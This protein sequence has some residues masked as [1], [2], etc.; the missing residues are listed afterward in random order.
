MLGRLLPIEGSILL[1]L[2]GL[3]RHALALEDVSF[4][5]A[6]LAS[7]SSCCQ[8]LLHFAIVL[9]SDKKF[10]PCS[11]HTRQPSHA[12]W[13]Y[14]LLREQGFPKRIICLGLMWP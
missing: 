13:M 7:H 11:E 5:L 3:R 4:E 1:V 12:C 14:V 9:G 6:C 8:Q 10:P 2:Y